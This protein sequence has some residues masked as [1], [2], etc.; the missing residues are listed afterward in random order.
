MPDFRRKRNRLP[1]HAYMG[2]RA[3]FVTICTHQRRAMLNDSILVDRLLGV[4]RKE[5]AVGEF[6]VYAYCF[7]P[8]H[9]HLALIALGD[10]CRL[11]AFLRAFKGAAA[12]EARGLGIRS[13]W[14]KGFYDHVIRTGEGL[15]AVAW[16][17]FSNP[18][19]KSLVERMDEWPY[20]GSFQF[21]WKKLVAP[22]KAFEPPWKNA[23]SGRTL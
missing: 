17:I 11:D 21:D 6:D 16:Y 7:M 23:N 13:L 18:L 4:L 10:S 19:R 22:P 5:C 8:D 1:R 12:S 15:A 14:Q 3:Y 2:R 20:S 9:L